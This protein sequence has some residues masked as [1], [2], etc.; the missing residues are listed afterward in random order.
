MKYYQNI[1]K[2]KLFHLEIVKWNKHNLYC[3]S[4]YLNH[5]ISV[6]SPKANFIQM[7]FFEA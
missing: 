7:F 3:K 5:A 4:K 1:S 2:D 6:I